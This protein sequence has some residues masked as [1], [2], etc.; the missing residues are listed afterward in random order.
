MIKELFRYITI[1]VPDYVRDMGYLKEA[2]AIEARYQRCK[3]GWQSHIDNTKETITSVIEMCGNREK[4]VVLG[5]GSLLD[6][7]IRELSLSFNQ[8]VLVDIVLM[9]SMKM[10]TSIFDNVRLITADVTGIAEKIYFSKPR[11]NSHLP[12]PEPYLP[13]C[14]DH[15]SLVISLNLLSQLS[16]IPIQYLKERLKW[17]D[18]EY[19]IL[20][21][22][23]LM[24]S[25]FE[26]LKALRCPVCLISDWQMSY[27]DKDGNEIERHITA[28]LLA[29]VKP[30]RQWTWALV[31]YGK[32]SRKYS[33]EMTVSALL[34]N[35]SLA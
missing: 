14:D 24:K 27:L 17:K 21:E 30:Y 16:Y 33:V 31:P 8:V 2:I 6:L 22:N 10:V 15:T 13:D 3:E 1:S 34:M 35:L 11:P 20:W 18:S 12:P 4:V 9:P 29:K 26:A 25:H 7:P 5:C 28:P 19:L 32:E 23:E